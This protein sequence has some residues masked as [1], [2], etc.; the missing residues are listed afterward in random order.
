MSALCSTLPAIWVLAFLNHPPSEQEEIKVGGAERRGSLPSTVW[1]RCVFAMR[2]LRSLTEASTGKGSLAAWGPGTGRGQPVSGTRAPGNAETPSSTPEERSPAPGQSHVFWDMAVL[3]CHNCTPW[4][5]GLVPLQPLTPSS[6][7][8]GLG[9]GCL[10]IVELPLQGRRHLLGSP[11]RGASLPGPG[12]P[13]LAWPGVGA[14]GGGWGPP[15]GRSHNTP[16][17]LGS[18]AVVLSLRL[19]GSW[20]Q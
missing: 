13:F 11:F 3:A 19:L 2:G 18:P 4:E 5:K 14:S 10:L 8:G 17:L 15:K 1:Q 20:W 7:S 9:D 6:C 16:T 12:S